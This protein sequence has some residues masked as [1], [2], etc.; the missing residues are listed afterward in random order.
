MSL[1]S[2]LLHAA[3]DSYNEDNNK[4]LTNVTTRHSFASLRVNREKLSQL[5][6]NFNVK[7]DEKTIK[8]T[9]QRSSGRCWEFAGHNILRRIMINKYHLEEDFEFSQAYF[10]FWDKFERL[11]YNLNRI[12]E[13]VDLPSDDRLIQTILAD[14]T[15]D[16]GQW[17][18][19]VNIVEKYGVVPKSAYPESFHSSNSYGLN[20]VLNTL[21]RKYARSVFTASKNNARYYFTTLRKN[22]SKDVYHI[23]CQSLGVPPKQFN[24]SGENSKIVFV[25]MINKNFTPKSFYQEFISPHFNFDDY[26]CLINDPREEHPFNQLYTVDCLGNVE[27]GKPVRYF[28]V[29]ISKLSQVVQKSLEEGEAVWFGCDVNQQRIESFMDDKLDD[30]DHLFKLSEPIFGESKQDKLRFGES[31]MT[32][33]MVFTGCYINKNNEV[34]RYQV[35][36]SW[37]SK[38]FSSSNPTAK[39]EDQLGTSDGYYTMSQTWFNKYVYEVVVNKKYLTSSLLEKYQNAVENN[40]VEKLPLWDPMGAL[41]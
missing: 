19:F 20:K 23:L 7:A 14:P 32:H 34:E 11:N 31:L 27:E 35:E 9:N 12:I 4:A 24:W 38:S 22:F 33:A 3:Q 15:C 17:D 16:G 10:F 39:F 30:L 6:K 40:N 18:M 21:F 36:N 28:N 29:H 5:S 26:V 8:V 2:S 41:A 13:N 37:G 25:Q 1:H